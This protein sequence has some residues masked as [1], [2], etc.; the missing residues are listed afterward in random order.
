MKRMLGVLFV[1][2]LLIAAI[3]MGAN[4]AGSCMVIVNKTDLTAAPNHTISAGKGTAAWNEASRT[5]TLTNAMIDQFDVDPANEWRYCGVYTNSDEPITVDLV[6]ENTIIFEGDALGTGIFAKAGMT[7]KGTGTLNLRTGGCGLEIDD[8]VTKSAEIKITG[9]AK[10]N[11]GHQGDTYLPVHGMIVQDDTGSNTSR[12]IIIEGQ[13]TQVHCLVKECALLSGYTDGSTS[14][15]DIIIRNKAVVEAKSTMNLPP[16]CYAEGNFTVDD[17]QLIV[18]SSQGE[19][20]RASRNLHFNKAAV[21]VKAMYNPLTAGGDFTAL[22]SNITAETK[23]E[24]HNGIWSEGNMK[25]Q[26]GTMKFVS[27]G[28][29]LYSGENV[30]ITDTLIDGETRDGLAIMAAKDILLN[31]AKLKLKTPHNYVF[32][33]QQGTLHMNGAEDN[34]RNYTQSYMT[35]ADYNA[36]NAAKTKAEKLDA[37]LY[38]N[39]DAVTTAIKAIDLKKNFEQQ[40]EVDA[41]AKAIEDALAALV[42][43]PADYTAVDA[44][45]AKVNG[46][47]RTQY[48]DLSKV[49]AAAAAVVRGKDITQ[50]SEVDAMAKAIEDALNSLVEKVVP[51]PVKLPKTGDSSH[52]TLNLVVCAAALAGAA[53]LVKKRRK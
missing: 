5:L 37:A 39:F 26:G 17:A 32:W 27:D 41:M 25:F 28:S 36:V 14:P 45:L 50:Q 22:Q 12:K 38:K 13:G 44:A 35:P 6:G 29:G 1:I 2:A 23:A 19:G 24:G 4:A 46:L 42:L 47:D 8:S 40:S 51:M 30:D 11:I 15:C 48:T 52:M 10:I 7:V 18:D 53:V 21:N 34:W 49:D 3:P 31:Q 43:K 33:P 20:I 9:G 16:I